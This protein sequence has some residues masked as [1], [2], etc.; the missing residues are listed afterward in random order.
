MNQ[1][2]PIRILFFTP[3]LGGGGAEMHLLRVVNHLDRQNFQPSIAVVRS[4]GSY[5]TALAP[6][7]SLHVL[8]T[9]RIRSSTVQMLRSLRPLRKLIQQEQPD[10]VCSVLGHANTI[11]ALAIQNLP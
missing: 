4:G 6:D 9:G 1:S 2:R 11:A 10:I 3:S 7:V 8:K 5:E